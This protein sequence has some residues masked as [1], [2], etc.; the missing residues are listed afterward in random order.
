M[1]TPH[2][3][4]PW[5]CLDASAASHSGAILDRER[6]NGRFVHLYAAGY[7]AAF[8]RSAGRLRRMF[9]DA[10]ISVPH[11]ESSPFPVVMASVSDEEFRAYA[12]R[13]IVRTS[14]TAPIRFSFGSRWRTSAADGGAGRR[15][16]SW[17]RPERQPSGHSWN[18]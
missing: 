2:T 1:D 14:D 11:F 18:E 8:E 9:P 12:W 10:G 4:A 17:R 6:D 13:H 5:L 16:R 3:A 15:W 7:R